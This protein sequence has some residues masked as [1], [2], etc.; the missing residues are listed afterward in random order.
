MVKLAIPPNIK[1]P[2]SVTSDKT[3]IT[4]VIEIKI[5][6]NFFNLFMIINGNNNINTDLLK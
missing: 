3:D 4:K 2:F 5:K 6:D 1:N